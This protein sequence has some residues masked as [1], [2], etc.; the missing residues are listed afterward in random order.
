M[1]RPVVAL[2]K[3][4]ARDRHNQARAL[5][6]SSALPPH[7]PSAASHAE[8]AV[9]G[10]HGSPR[11]V[12]PILPIL[13]IPHEPLRHNG[14]LRL[15]LQGCFRRRE[16]RESLQRRNIPD[17]ALQRGI[18]TMNATALRGSLMPANCQQGMTGPAF[19]CL[20]PHPGD[21]IF[22]DSR[23]KARMKEKKRRG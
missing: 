6:A 15:G 5:T 10:V 11:S 13:P 17:A 18:R 22:D 14:P 21:P 8:H 23:S 7:P 20:K 16:R 3:A 19:A 1:K 4:P 2:C 12:Y 9:A